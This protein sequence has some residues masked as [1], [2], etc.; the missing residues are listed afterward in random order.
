MDRIV[1]FYGKE[2]ED[3]S[4]V[5]STAFESTKEERQSLSS[6]TKVYAMMDGCMLLTRKKGA[7]KEMKLGRIF[8]SDV[9]YELSSTRNWIKK[10]TY[11]A[12]FGGHQV[13]L[14]K[15]EYWLDE[16]LHLNERLVF[17]NDGAKWIWNWVEDNYPLATQI[18][19][20]FH[21]MEYLTDFAKVY[22]KNKSNRKDWV[23]ERKLELLNDQVEQVIKKVS[24]LSCPK[25][26]NKK[27][28]RN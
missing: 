2:L 20:F 13:F 6:D 26:I 19:D 8:N 18:L 3:E 14:D 28:K 21:A 7:W 22:F 16:Y 12:H 15:L 25:K 9:H 4:G 1:K 27:L 24:A 23:T 10:S 5:A 17:I 11:T